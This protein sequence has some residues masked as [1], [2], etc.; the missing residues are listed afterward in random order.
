[1]QEKTLFRTRAAQVLAAMRAEGVEVEGPEDL[2]EAI[3]ED[4]FAQADANGHLAGQGIAL[5]RRRVLLLCKP[6]RSL[7]KK[8]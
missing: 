5:C 6:L 8:I 1:M 4:C 2:A 3:T 7:L